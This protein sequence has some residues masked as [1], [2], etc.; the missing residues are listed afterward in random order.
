[1]HNP[2]SLSMPVMTE[3]APSPAG[4]LWLRALARLPLPLLRAAGWVLGATLYV[5]APRR[6]RIVE[7]NLAAC[8]PDASD[9]VR[10]RW[11]WETFKYFGQSFVDRV[12]LWHAPEATVRQRMTLHGAEQLPQGGAL[13][14]APHFFGLDAGWSALTQAS[15]RPWWTLY[16]PQVRPR[17]DA[18]VYQGRQRHDA[19]NLVSRHDGMRPLVRALRDGAAVYL[20]P[21]MDLGA[22]NAVFAPFFG[23]SAATVTTLGRLARSAGVPVLPVVTRLVPRGYEVEVLPAWQGYPSGDD[24]TDARRMNAELEGWIRA[25]PG[26]YHWLHRRF[27]TRPAGEPGLYRD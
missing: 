6:R 1:M 12:W 18:W 19:A 26:Q 14:F 11:T 23:V 10:R 3:S 17:I 25:M 20:L 4:P 27:K 13:C 5:A 7:T 16:M 2:A 9:A 22:D 24:T 8:F 21:D 15:E